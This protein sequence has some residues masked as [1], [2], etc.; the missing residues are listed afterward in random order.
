MTS[1]VSCGIIYIENIAA[2][3]ER[4]PRALQ[5]THFDEG[6]N[7]RNREPPMS[8]KNNLLKY[9]KTIKEIVAQN[10]AFVR[11]LLQRAGLSTA[12]SSFECTMRLANHVAAGLGV[13][14]EEEETPAQRRAKYQLCGL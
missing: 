1:N 8:Q 14:Q 12:G 11:E 2:S 4:A 5:A 10:E 7:L 3:G 13:Q 9:G 6:L